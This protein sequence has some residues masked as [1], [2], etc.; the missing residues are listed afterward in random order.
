MACSRVRFTFFKEAGEPTRDTG[1]TAMES[2][3]VSGRGKK[4]SFLQSAYTKCRSYSGS[5]PIVMRNS[6]AGS[7]A[8]VA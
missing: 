2:C 7:R 8:A 5:Y 1:W 4:F 6:S 3:F